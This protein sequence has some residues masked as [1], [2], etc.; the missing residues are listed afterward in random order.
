MP[1]EPNSDLEPRSDLDLVQDTL[2]GQVDSF[3]ELVQR[4]QQ[5][6]FGVVVR[7]LRDRGV[8]EEIT[9]D[10][11]V[12]AYRKL[13]TFDQAR[14]FSSWLFRIA[15]NAAIDELRKRRVATVP[16]ENE[17]DDTSSDPLDRLVDHNIA[18]PEREVTGQALRQDLE[19]IL[20]R[21]RPE[22]AE[23]MVL[24]FIEQRSYEEI[25]EIMD[26]PMGTVKTYIFRA[27]K[28]TARQMGD[29]GWGNRE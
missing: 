22:Y 19:D 26:L 3:S 6:V 2:A 16:L 13:E 7:M 1:A 29:R 17:V 15:H 8:A 14:K 5:P 27:R 10:V 24:R 21:L 18:D 23:V 11:L 25:S 28:A 9:Q 12:R 4:Y 20:S